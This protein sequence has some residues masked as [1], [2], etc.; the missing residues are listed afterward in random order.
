MDETLTMVQ[1]VSGL[2][3]QIASASGQQLAGI[4]QV[5]AA[6]A[7]LDTIT[8]HNAALVERSA[9]LA[10]Q[11]QVQAQTVAEAVQVFRLEGAAP[12][13]PDAVALRRSARAQLALRAAG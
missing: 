8:Q 12:A 6:V 4:S 7:Q 2:I 1:Q 11:V 3:G 10:D 13:Q 5:N 9:Q